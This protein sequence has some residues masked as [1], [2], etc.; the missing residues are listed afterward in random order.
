MKRGVIILVIII[1]LVVLIPIIYVMYIFLSFADVHFDQGL[2]LDS[3][4]QKI[5]REYF[6]KSKVSALT[7]EPIKINN[8]GTYLSLEGK[9]YLSFIFGS[10]VYHIFNGIIFY[11]EMMWTD[12]SEY[13]NRGIYFYNLQSGQNNRLSNCENCYGELIVSSNDNFVVLQY[14]DKLSAYGDATY[15]RGQKIVAFSNDG[16]TYL[17][18][19][20]KASDRSSVKKFGHSFLIEK[21]FFFLF[22]N[23]SY[24]VNLSSLKETTIFQGEIDYFSK[25]DITSLTPDE[26]IGLC[27]EGNPPLYFVPSCITQIAISENDSLI[28]QKI[29]ESD[30]VRVNRT[31]TFKD[32][33][34]YNFALFTKNY[35]ICD[36][37]SD[38]PESNYISSYRNR[39]VKMIEGTW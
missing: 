8:T 2:N 1:G 29:L 16:K 36:K 10:S 13:E 31:R 26:I 9:K 28:C 30:E 19:D 24:M 37:L 5:S 33:C 12:F 4:V 32:D 17:I 23:V 6:E 22:D 3:H 11:K 14:P 27:R 20:Y 34:Y 35:S 18:L 38:V 15:N 7:E 39:C 25:R 21:S